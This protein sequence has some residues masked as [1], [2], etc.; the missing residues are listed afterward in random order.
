[1][2][3]GYHRNGFSTLSF[4]LAAD[5]LNA[6]SDTPLLH[7]RA[8]PQDP[9]MFV[10]HHSEDHEWFYAT[11]YTVQHGE[12]A[13]RG[14]Q[15]SA[16]ECRAT[17]ACLPPEPL[18]PSLV[19]TLQERHAITIGPVPPAPTLQPAIEQNAIATAMPTHLAQPAALSPPGIPPTPNTVSEGPNQT[20]SSDDLWQ[21]V[22]RMIKAADVGDWTSFRKDNE[23]LADMPPGR[24][25]WVQAKAMV[26]MEDHL[27]AQ[28]RARQPPAPPRLD[29]PT[30]PDHALYRQAREGVHKLDREYG[31][32]TNIH[33]DM[34]AASLVVAARRS[35]FAAIDE[36]YLSADRQQ[37]IV[38][39]TSSIHTALFHATVN[40]LEGL[41]APMEQSNQQWQQM[42]HE[43]AQEQV[44]ERAQV[45]SQGFSR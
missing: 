22:D 30:H 11:R 14:A 39:D 24:E 20:T 31:R 12:R 6:L 26:D 13:L 41:N 21:R 36:V 43:R 7:K 19:A 44:R 5:Y 40:T 23:I 17:I 15:R 38:R 2:G 18:D 42:M 25:L 9:Q 34:L 29:D 32:T 4:N 16:P 28:E 45:K 1:V 33:S 37:V 27:A 35:H 8:L 3:G 10:I